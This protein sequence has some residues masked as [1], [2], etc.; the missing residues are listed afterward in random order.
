M[1]FIIPTI[2]VLALFGAYSLRNSLFDVLIAIGMGILGAIFKRVGVP[3]APV[4][5]GLVLGP[6]IETNLSRSLRISEARG[7]SLPEYMLSSS[8]GIG[9]LIGVLV[10]MGIVV[11]MRRR[12]ASVE[13]Q[14][15]ASRKGAG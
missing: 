15:E 14:V 9:L 2:L 1:D 7:M 10:L 11:Q 4:V 6:M 13:A 3:P 8:L 12:M 5:I